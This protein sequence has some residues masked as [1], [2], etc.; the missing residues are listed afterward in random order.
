MSAPGAKGVVAWNVAL[1]APIFS[2]A[3]VAV[4]GRLDERSCSRTDWPFEI[5]PGSAVNGPP[6]MLYRPP[7]TLIGALVM[8]VIDTAFETTSV[9]SGTLTASMKVNG[10]GRSDSR[11]IGTCELK[12]T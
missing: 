3:N 2:V 7:R 10:A 8:Q 11:S 6:S 1:A 4:L 12:R 9:L 5:N